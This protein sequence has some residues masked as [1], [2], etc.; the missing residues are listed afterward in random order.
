MLFAAKRDLVGEAID[1]ISLPQHA[2]EAL[3][4]EYAATLR[5]REPASADRF[6]Q[7]INEEDGFAERALR[8]AANAVVGATLIITMEPTVDFETLRERFESAQ[9]DQDLLN[10]RQ[11]VMDRAISMNK[12]LR[13]YTRLS[14][15]LI[16]KRQAIFEKI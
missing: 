14:R 6:D 8:Q 2:L 10:L 16:E 7:R 13:N 12:D 1:Q 3:V 5:G 15:Q 11:E 4:S 9:G